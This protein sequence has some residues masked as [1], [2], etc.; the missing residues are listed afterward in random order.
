MRRQAQIS[1][2]E[3]WRVPP[4]WILVRVSTDDGAEGWGEAIVAKRPHAVVGAIEDLREVVV[5]E[6]AGRIEDLWQRMHRGGFFRGGPILSTAAAAIEQAL[7]DLKG[8]AAALPV[9]ELLGGRV[10]EHV[11]AYAWVGGDDPSDVVAQTKARIEDG[12]DAVKMNVGAQLDWLVPSSAIDAVVGRVDAIRQAFGRD[13]GIAV[14]FHGRV[15]LTAARNLLRELEPYGLLWVEEPVAP[16]CEDDL[17]SLRAMGSVPLATGERLASRYDFR[18]LLTQRAVDIIQPDVS[19]TGLAELEKLCRMAEAY[20]I[21]VA[22]HSPNGP[23]SLAASLQVGFCCGN[24]VIQEFSRGLHYHQGY[25]GLPAGDLV[26]YLVQPGQLQ[27]ENGAFTCPDGPGLGVDIDVDAVRSRETAWHM[28][29]PRWRHAD[30][31]LAEW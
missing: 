19:L 26:D 18:R 21:A 13:L 9:H 25:D 30:G 17:V 1:A 5:G 23:I 12:F 20:D 7:W 31:R 8:R 14:D 27:P 16:E 2:V 29:D 11:R 6:E 3:V 4:R 10:R 28:P 24:V 22:P 15:H